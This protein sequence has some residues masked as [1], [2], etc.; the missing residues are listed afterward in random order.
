[1]RF[2]VGDHLHIVSNCRQIFGKGRKL[3]RYCPASLTG[4]PFDQCRL[5]TQSGLQLRFRS[6]RTGPYLATA[7]HPHW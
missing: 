7:L 6:I 2:D 5:A 3:A 4:W 1:M